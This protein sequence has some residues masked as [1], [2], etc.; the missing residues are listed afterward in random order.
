LVKSLCSSR[1][2]S[3]EAPRLPL[4]GCSMP[5]TCGCAYKHHDDRRVRARRAEELHGVRRFHWT[6]ENRRLMQDRRA[7]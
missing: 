5:S 6:R 2:L 3:A 4:Y 7:E 1:F